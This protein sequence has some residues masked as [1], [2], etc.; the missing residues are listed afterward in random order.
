MPAGKSTWVVSLHPTPPPTPSKTGYH[1]Y[2]LVWTWVGQQNGE[3]EEEDVIT[4]IRGGGEDEE[5]ESVTNQKSCVGVIVNG[6]VT[7]VLSPAWNTLVSE[8]L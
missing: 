7:L 1:F 2:S 5:E 6:R 4:N 3:K 8:D